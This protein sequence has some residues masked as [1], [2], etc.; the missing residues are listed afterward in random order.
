VRKPNYFILAILW[1]I[2]VTVLSLAKIEGLDT[3]INI[4]N[5][6]KVVHFVFYFLFFILWFLN[7]STRKNKTQLL[8]IV[9][10]VS[11]GYGLLMEGLQGVIQTNRTPDLADV[12]ANT[13]GAFCALLVTVYFLSKKKQI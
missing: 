13:S 4:P 11:V 8:G 12:V 10:L 7:F 3:P 6:D 5:K 1:T 2:L 9:L